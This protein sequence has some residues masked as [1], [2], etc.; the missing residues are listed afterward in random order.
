MIKTDILLEDFRKS[1]VEIENINSITGGYEIC[2]LPDLTDS[3]CT[4][5]DQGCCDVDD[6]TAIDENGVVRVVG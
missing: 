4:G 1:G 5:G 3:G 6:A 2:I